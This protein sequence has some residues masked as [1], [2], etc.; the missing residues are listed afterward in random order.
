MMREMRREKFEG[1]VDPRTKKL[2]GFVC[3][4]RHRYDATSYMKCPQ[5]GAP[6]IAKIETAEVSTLV[7]YVLP[8]SVPRDWD[9]PL[10]RFH[11]KKFGDALPVMDATSVQT[12][13]KWGPMLVG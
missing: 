8:A 6:P 11:R 3:P 13:Q 4:E 5:H 10:L 2:V 12:E 1:D 9:S 7:S